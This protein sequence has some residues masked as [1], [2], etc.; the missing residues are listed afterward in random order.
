[1]S[2]LTITAGD[3]SLRIVPDKIVSGTVQELGDGPYEMSI[4]YFGNTI[5]L[6]TRPTVS[7]TVLG[8]QPKVEN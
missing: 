5:N 4:S 8:S 7:N 2:S 3:Y 1:M 6:T